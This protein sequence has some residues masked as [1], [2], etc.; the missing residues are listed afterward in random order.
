MQSEILTAPPKRDESQWIGC[1]GRKESFINLEE[2]GLVDCSSFATL[3]D[4]ICLGLL[5]VD[6]S[7]TGGSHKHMGIV[8]PEFEQDQSIDYGQ[9]IANFTKE[10]FLRFISIGDPEYEIDSD[11]WKEY[12]F[13]EDAEIPMTKKQFQYLK[14]RY[15]VY[16]PWKAH[17]PFI[18]G[19]YN[20]TNKHF[21][22]RDFTD[23][24]KDLFPQTCDF[25][26]SLPFMSIGRCD[27]LGL[28]AND[29]GTVHRDN[30]ERIDSP[31]IMDFI[32]ISPCENK[33]LFLYQ[34]V[35]KEESFVR[36]KA[37]TFNDM[38]YHGVAADPWFRY[39]I[40]IDGIFKE[41]FRA[42]LAA[43]N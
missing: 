30:Y 3:H 32:T 16:F 19:V 20:W 10:E 23:L 42:K 39:S 2:E 8:P 11:R 33:R 34:H 27:L 38:N 4:E 13:G 26:R 7:Y 15:G 31:P 28:E 40:R 25:I 1:Q 24:V 21:F 17:Y 35:T 5:E 36:G 29:F 41:E 43:R 6:F 37:Y 14:M 9:V 18:E 12:T 22:N